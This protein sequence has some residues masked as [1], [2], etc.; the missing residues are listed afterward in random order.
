MLL[1]LLLS[2]Y[3][4][5]HINFNFR[6]NIKVLMEF[7]EGEKWIKILFRYLWKKKLKTFIFNVIIVKYRMC[8]TFY[9]S[10]K[11]KRYWQ[12]VK[13]ITFDGN[14]SVLKQY[15]LLPCNTFYFLQL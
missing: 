15:F 7:N 2:H 4:T 1:P 12:G 10:W 8:Y 14:T 11:S 6:L 13:S 9:Y 5:V 3:E